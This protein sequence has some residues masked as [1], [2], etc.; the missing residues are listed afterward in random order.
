MKRVN[1][2]ADQLLQS[3]A[4]LS[5]DVT[6]LASWLVG[7]LNCELT[8]T[9][10]SQPAKLPRWMSGFLSPLFMVVTGGLLP[11]A[12]SAAPTPP[13]YVQGNSATPTSQATVRVTYMA[14]Q[15]AG[16]LNVVIVGWNDSTAQV[17]SVTDSKGNV[18]QL[19]IGPTQLIGAVGAQSISQSVY[20]SKNIAAAA[21]GTNTV[22][23]KFG[24]AAQYPDI[25]ILE[26]SGIDPV[27]PV[28]LAAAFFNSGSLS[29]T[30]TVVITNSLDLLVGANTVQTSNS[31]P[32]TGFTERLLT[33]DGDVVEDR[34]VS[35]PGLYSAIAPLTAPGEYVMQL[36]AFRATGSS[37][38]PPDTTPPTVNIR[39]PAAGATLSG[40]NTVTVSASDIGSGVTSVQLQ[41]DGVP[42]GTAVTTTP[43]LFFLDTS[44]FA[45]GTHSLTASAWDC[46]NNMGNAHPV[47]VTFSNSSPGNPAQSGVWSGAVWLPLVSVNAA[48]LPGGKVL[49]YDGQSLGPSAIVWNPATDTVDFVPAPANIFCSGLEQLADGRILV[50]GGHIIAHNGL[51]IADIFDPSTE[52]W[53][54]LPNMAYPRWYPST[55]TLP[56]GNVIVI[57]G[58]TNCSECDEPV[59]EIYNPSTNSWSQLTNAPFSF[60]YYPQVYVLPDGRVLVP[61]TGEAPIGSEVL[62]LSVPAWSGVGGSVVDGGSAAMYLPDEILKEGTTVDP[63]NPTQPSVAAAYVLD[64]TQ[65]TPTW[66][67]VTSM[68]FPRTYHNTTLLPDGTVLVTG[69]GTTTGATDTAHAVLP[70]EVWSPTTQTWTTLASMS[71]PRLYHSEG[72]LLPDGRVL[73]SGSGR[74]VDSPQPTDQYSAEFFSP[75]YLFKGPRPSI[76]SAPSQLSYGHNF[77]VRTPHAGRI[78]TVSLIRYGSVTHCTNMGQRYLPLSFSAGTRSLTV[79]APANANLAPPGNYLLFL[80]NTNG[81][82]SVA[83]TV[84]F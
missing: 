28:D 16:D 42:Y 68:T 49:L 36:V 71:A 41:V 5:P 39:V 56:N 21:A 32:G 50:A 2:L 25:R 33:P 84:H 69:G 30:G 38:S 52:S 45:N 12:V 75:P 34:E 17:S 4:L 57:S 31:G 63:D 7:R 61:G 78:A 46:G 15:T 54:V 22:T 51:P 19:A 3:L 55:T 48:L 14:A 79:R 37:G 58:E 23:V 53:T 82:P 73:I 66:R 62:D 80:V 8:K 40:T 83:A 77:T 10:Y 67:P 81:V 76:T 9:A 26:Y 11:N 70:A 1:T 64:M 18:Y 59:A 60:P 44:K 29:T 13:K 20:Y 74:F 27:N 24:S 47:S 43:Y 6:Q 35:V 65:T 72:L